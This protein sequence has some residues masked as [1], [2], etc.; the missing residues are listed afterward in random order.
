V[1]L[2]LPRSDGAAQGLEP[3]EIENLPGAHGETI[4]VVEDDPDVR[5]MTVAM[6]EGLD[7]ATLQ[8]PDGK[9]ALKI[10][11]TVPDVKL[12]FSDVVLPGGMSGPELARVIRDDRPD[13]GILFTSGYTED[14]MLHQGWFGNGV[15]LLNKPFNRRDLAQEIRAAIDLVKNS[16]DNS[17]RSSRNNQDYPIAD[18]RV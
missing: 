13:I 5:D 3:L 10:L 12:L 15:E 6:L 16:F 11:E 1:K 18:R 17:L 9:S 8:C 4:L 14:A 7:Y 2:Y